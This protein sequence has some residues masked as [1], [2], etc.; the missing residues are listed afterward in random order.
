MSE[1]LRSATLNF[2]ETDLKKLEILKS[3]FGYRKNIEMIRY[4]MTEAIERMLEEPMFQK[5]SETELIDEANAAICK[6]PMHQSQAQKVPNIVN[7][8]A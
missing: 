6:N 5:G 8:Y 2:N 7:A 4:L 1:N 3:R